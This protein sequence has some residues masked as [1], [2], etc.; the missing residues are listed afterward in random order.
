M[1]ESHQ[2]HHKSLL[3]IIYMDDHR[4]PI[5][6]S[7]IWCAVVVIIMV[8]RKQT[9]NLRLAG[10]LGG[11]RW[12]CRRVLLG[13]K[14]RQAHIARFR[15]KSQTVYLAQRV[16]FLLQKNFCFYRRGVLQRHVKSLPSARLQSYA[17]GISNRDSSLSA[18]T[19][20]W[21][22]VKNAGLLDY[23]AIRK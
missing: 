7:I 6:E 23:T 15:L 11:L 4:T 8:C 5:A 20:P 14:G 12:C 1:S 3:R 9:R 17:S 19:T 2:S 16:H 22:H 13:G 21:N 18:D 10:M